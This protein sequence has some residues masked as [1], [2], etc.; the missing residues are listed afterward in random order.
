MNHVPLDPRA[1]ESDDVALCDAQPVTGLS[2][3]AGLTEIIFA[4]L[5]VAVFRS[6]ATFRLAAASDIMKMRWEATW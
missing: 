1:R 5:G 2:D 6:T 4:M 3:A